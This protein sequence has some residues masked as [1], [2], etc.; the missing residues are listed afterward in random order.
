MKKKINKNAEYLKCQKLNWEKNRENIENVA[1]FR[2]CTKCIFISKNSSI[3]QI[4]DACD[5]NGECRSPN[6]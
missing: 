4:V 2:F 6:K 1:I 5:V 3:F